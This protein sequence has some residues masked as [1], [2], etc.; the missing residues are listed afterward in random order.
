MLL[1]EIVNPMKNAV[2]IGFRTI[3]SGAIIFKVTNI[4]GEKLSKVLDF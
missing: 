2:H 1:R 4:H 3:H